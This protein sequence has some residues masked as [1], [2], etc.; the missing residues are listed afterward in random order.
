[1]NY[2]PV[3]VLQKFTNKLPKTSPC[4]SGTPTELKKQSKY[5]PVSVV[6]QIQQQQ[7]Q[8]FTIKLFQ[9]CN[10]YKFCFTIKSKPKTSTDPPVSVVQQV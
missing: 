3:S 9:W 7:Q 8:Q 2:L 10:K 1:M 6:Q 4:F 5:L